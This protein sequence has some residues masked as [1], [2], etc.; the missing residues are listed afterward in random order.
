MA[1]L[2][3][4]VRAGGELETVRVAV[5]RCGEEKLKHS[6]SAHICRCCKRALFGK[7]I[8]LT[9]VLWK[10]LGR[11]GVRCGGP[12]GGAR[13]GFDLGIDLGIASYLDFLDS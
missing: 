8:G 9:C 3:A 6:H 11:D 7:K 1:E 5:I 10:G 13:V 2:V 4:S 12:G